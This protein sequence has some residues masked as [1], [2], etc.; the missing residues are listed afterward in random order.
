MYD[1]YGR[2]GSKSIKIHI[3]A[4]KSEWWKERRSLLSEINFSALMFRKGF[5]YS[6]RALCVTAGAAFDYFIF[7]LFYAPSFVLVRRFPSANC[8]GR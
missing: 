1:L 5:V 4:E 8:R 2:H 3:K 7:F 6:P